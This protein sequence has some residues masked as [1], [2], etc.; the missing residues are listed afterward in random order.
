MTTTVNQDW[1][2]PDWPLGAIIVVTPG[3]PVGV[4]SLVDPTGKN[5]PSNPTPGG[6]AGGA[7]EYTVRAH[8][9]QFQAIKPSGSGYVYNTGFTY[10]VRKGGSRSDSGSVIKVLAAGETYFLDAAPI[11]DNVWSPYRY[12]ID[13][14]YAGDAVQVTLLIG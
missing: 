2:G 14:D 5:D 3:T 1:A 4:M 11:N 13:A 12:Y 7:N 6:V 9:I 10:I 8:Q